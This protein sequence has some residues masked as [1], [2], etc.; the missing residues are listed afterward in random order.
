MGEITS[1]ALAKGSQT[2]PGKKAP[3]ESEKLKVNKI[4]ETFKLE[5]PFWLHGLEDE[6]KVAKKYLWVAKLHHVDAEVAQKAAERC[7]VVFPNKSGPT[8]GEFLKL[9]R[10]EPAHQDWKVPALPAPATES[11]A[12]AELAKMKEKL[13]IQTT[14]NTK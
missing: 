9:C 4:F 5:Y 10:V 14:T 7:P 6:Q 8:I 11:V 3:H 2:Q 13:G 12:N 1:Q